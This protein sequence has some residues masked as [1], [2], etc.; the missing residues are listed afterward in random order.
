VSHKVFVLFYLLF[1]F[2]NHSVN[3]FL[4]LLIIITSLHIEDLI[5]PIIVKLCF[6][7]LIG[8]ALIK[9][10][11][12]LEICVFIPPLFHFIKAVVNLT[13]SIMIL[14]QQVAIA[15]NFASFINILF[16]SILSHQLSLILSIRLIF[17]LRP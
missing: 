11:F 15:N 10:N 8:N 13:P 3:V 2:F 14:K 1:F 9:T 6:A 5:E 7:K 17:V 12:F 16:P 4:F